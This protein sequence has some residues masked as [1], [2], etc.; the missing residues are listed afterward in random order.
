MNLFG[1][2][3]PGAVPSFGNTPVRYWHHLS[4]LKWHTFTWWCAHQAAALCGRCT[5]ALSIRNAGNAQRWRCPVHGD[6]CDVCGNLVGLTLDAWV[7]RDA[8][9]KVSHYH[10]ACKAFPS[11][12]DGGDVS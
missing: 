11:R 6:R 8:Q 1:P 7:N 5:C 12:D 4:A 2:I 3:D 10:V 9:G